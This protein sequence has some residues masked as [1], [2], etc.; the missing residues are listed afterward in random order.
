[1]KPITLNDEMNKAAEDTEVGVR[2]DGSTLSV[3]KALLKKRSKSSAAA[4]PKPLPLPLP[5]AKSPEK[6]YLGKSCETEV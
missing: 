1:M 2:T 6:K 4:L 5:L 3:G